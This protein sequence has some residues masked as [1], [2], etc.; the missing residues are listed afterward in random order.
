MLSNDP[1][2]QFWYS[3]G[4]FM[5]DLCLRAPRYL[6]EDLNYPDRL[7]PKHVM[8]E[9]VNVTLVDDDASRLLAQDTL[10]YPY[11]GH[12]V[13]RYPQRIRLLFFYYLYPRVATDF[14]QQQF[15]RSRH[16]QSD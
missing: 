10:Y 8:Q 14:L 2:I 12:H 13:M 7:T 15:R 3:S 5:T 4:M 9:S 1:I 11:Y 16:A 6:I